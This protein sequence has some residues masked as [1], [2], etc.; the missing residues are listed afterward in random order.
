[1]KEKAGIGDY[2][3]E[4]A[5]ANSALLHYLQ[6]HRFPRIF[7]YL[8]LLDEVDI[9]PFLT[10]IQESTS[11]ALPRCKADST[12]DFILMERTWEEST[13]S[14]SFGI[15]EPIG[16]RIVQPTET[17]LILVP[18]MAF[19]PKGERLGRGKGFYDKYLSGYGPVHTLG[20]CRSYQLMEEIPI[21]SWDLCV[22][23]LLCGG[24]LQACLA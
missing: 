4:D 21:E 5:L 24:V 13:K 2:T 16:N 14:G 8:P 20:I 10:E 3:K 22:D 6:E 23:V 11:I 18:G 15:L 7:A 1:M 17:D 12:M 9:R 19:N